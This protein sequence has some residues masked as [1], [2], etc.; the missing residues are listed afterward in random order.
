MY[1]KVFES[2]YDG[3]LAG[4]WQALVTMQQLIVLATPDGV[5]DMTPDSIARRTT[6]PLEIIVAGIEHL[7]QPDPH[8]RSPDEG[9]RRIVRIEP[10][11]PWGWRLVNH[12]KYRDL[13]SQEQKRRADRERIAAVRAGDQEKRRGYVYFASAGDAIKIGYSANP[14]ARLND[15]QNG[16]P[17]KFELLAVVAGTDADERSLHAEFKELRIHG[18]WFKRSKA[19]LQKI[20]ELRARSAATENY[21]ADVAHTDADAGKASGEGKAPSPE[22]RGGTAPLPDCPHQKLIDLYHELLPTC[23]RVVEWNSERQALMRARWRE[24][25]VPN[26]KRPGYATEAAGIAFWRRYMGYV[27]NSEFLTGQADPTH[28]RTT[29][30]ADMEWLIRPKN[31]AKV[32]EGRYHSQRKAA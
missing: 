16:S 11:R 17:Q 24:Q 20:N 21:G 29:F 15:L 4:H 22:G 28:G 9:G 6:I 19:L 23:P 10:H 30:V 31:F 25:S 32:V 13:V 8:S 18:E 12:A 3:T 7:E 5:V 2:M 14:W 27:A 26:G 1:G